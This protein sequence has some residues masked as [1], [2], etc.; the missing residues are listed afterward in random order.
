[1]LRQI[2]HSWLIAGAAA[3]VGSLCAPLA[4]AQDRDYDR[5]RSYDQ[6]RGR[7]Y[8][9]DRMTRIEPGTVISVRTENAINSQEAGERD[10]WGTVDQDIRG[11]NGR[12]AIPRGSRVEMRVRTSPDNDLVLRLE[13]VMIEGNRLALDTRPDRIESNKDTGVVGAI[14][15]AL[16]G[17]VRGREVHV[18]ANSIVTFRVQTPAVVEAVHREDYDRK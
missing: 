3:L 6:D 12:L 4:V 9:H 17:Q 8:D 1:M 14:V 5:D 18:P 7:D 16:G 2:N 11:E 15:G 13:G 10:Y